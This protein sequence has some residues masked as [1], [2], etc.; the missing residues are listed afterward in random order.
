[1]LHREVPCTSVWLC[2]TSVG[3]EVKRSLLMLNPCTLELPFH[4]WCLRNPNRQHKPSVNRLWWQQTGWTKCVFS[5]WPFCAAQD[6]RVVETDAQLTGLFT[7]PSLAAQRHTH[8]QCNTVKQQSLATWGCLS[9]IIQY[10]SQKHH[11]SFPSHF[12]EHVF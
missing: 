6:E 11:E 9:T 1:M 4:L 3:K 10:K 7:W 12:R 2:I 8:P 5:E